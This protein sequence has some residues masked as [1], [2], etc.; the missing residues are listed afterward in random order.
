M[1]VAF[2][3]TLHQHLP[4]MPGML[5]HGVPVADTISTHDVTP[6]PRQPA[7][8]DDGVDVLACSS[9]HHQ[10]VDRLGDGLVATG[11]AL[12]GWSRRSSGSRT[13]PTMDAPW[14]LGVQ[15]HP[16]DTA[17]N[18]PAQ[19]AI[20]DG[21]ALLAKWP[22]LPGE[23]RR[24]ARPHPRV[25]AGRLRPGWPALFEHEAARIQRRARRPRSFGSTMW[26]RRP[27]PD[28]QRNR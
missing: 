2:G 23:A 17:A 3:G 22:G 12:T 19:Q 26:V 15:W 10:G 6:A 11:R 21:F 25:R 13:T 28:S 4:D 20:F 24:D 8:G 14:M 1:N 27:C 7:P 9:H 18:D 5:E 16:E